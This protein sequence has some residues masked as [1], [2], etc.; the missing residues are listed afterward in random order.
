MD[1]FQSRP[2]RTVTYQ[3]H[4][5]NQT[6]EEGKSFQRSL[7]TV[8]LLALQV[9]VLGVRGLWRPGEIRLPPQNE[10]CHQMERN[11]LTDHSA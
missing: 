5:N 3:L 11:E 2:T 10:I 9:R 7:P 8:S 1:R 6:R 4:H